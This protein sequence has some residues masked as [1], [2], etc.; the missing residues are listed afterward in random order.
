MGPKTSRGCQGGK[1]AHDQLGGFVFREGPD[2][3]ESLAL[4]RTI[5]RTFK[6]INITL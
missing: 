5:K 3:P 6:E 4:K 2:N 1:E